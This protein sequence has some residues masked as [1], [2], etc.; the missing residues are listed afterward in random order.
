MCP[1]PYRLAPAMCQALK[2]HRGRL[3]HLELEPVGSVPTS[4][5]EF[6]EAQSLCVL[7]LPGNADVASI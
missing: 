4:E 7:K 1:L 2:T 5:P 6:P 3:L